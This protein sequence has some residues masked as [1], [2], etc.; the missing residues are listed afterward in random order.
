[1]ELG[2][3]LDRLRVEPPPI[4]MEVTNIRRINQWRNETYDRLV[5][6]ARQAADQRQRMKLCT[7]ADQILVE[8]A[9]IVPIYYQ[10]ER[11]LVKPWV[12]NYLGA[13]TEH[14]FWRDVIIEPH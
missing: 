9:A 8:E 3:L 1:M 4:F 12:S 2:I 11:L 10:R 5:G 13:A 14:V 6:E 7:Q